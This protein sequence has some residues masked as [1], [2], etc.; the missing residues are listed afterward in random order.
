M[1]LLHFS[2]EDGFEL[3]DGGGRLDTGDNASGGNGGKR[4][5]ILSVVLHCEFFCCFLLLEDGCF[6]LGFGGRV[7]FFLGFVASL[8]LISC[9]ASNWEMIAWKCGIHKIPESKIEK[10]GSK[11]RRI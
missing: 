1:K 7:A 2:A 9:L 3:G 10:L 6:C 11:Q 5:S 8:N 4:R